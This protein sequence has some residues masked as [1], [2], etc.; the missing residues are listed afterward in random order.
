[1]RAKMSLRKLLPAT[2]EEIHDGFLCTQN[3]GLP[4]MQSKS[5]KSI[6]IIFDAISRRNGVI[7]SRTNDHSSLCWWFFW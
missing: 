5:L 3:P 1:M 2:S 7:F 4:K 6:F